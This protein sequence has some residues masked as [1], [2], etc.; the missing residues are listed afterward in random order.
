MIKGTMTKERIESWRFASSEEGGL[1]LVISPENADCESIWIYRLNLKKGEHYTLE[2]GEKEMNGVCVKGSALI[3]AE[4]FKEQCNWKDS[5]YLT[6]EMALKMEALEDCAFYLGA[7]VEEGYGKPFFRKY[8]D[9]LPLGEIHQIH[10]E[11]VGKREVFMTLNPE[12]EASRLICGITTGGNGAWTSWPPHEHEKDLEEVYCYFDMDSPHFGLH[13]SYINSGDTEGIVAHPVSSGVMVL[14]P[15][16]Y[17][18]TV[19]APGTRNTYFWV[20][21]AHSHESRRYDLAVADPMRQNQI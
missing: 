5:F 4:C 9:T 12:V 3:A 21:A 19:A 2:T 18:P 15:R 13:L 17:H 7:A 10:G 6:G 16:G 20:L 8:D 11:G 1:H 14:A